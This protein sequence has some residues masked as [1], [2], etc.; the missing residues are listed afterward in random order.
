MHHPVSD[1]FLIVFCYL[2]N[3]AVFIED[4]TPYKDWQQNFDSSK[5]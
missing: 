1:I 2:N 3:S 5:Q 4:K